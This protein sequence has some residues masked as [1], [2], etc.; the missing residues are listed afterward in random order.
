MG[1]GRC[2]KRLITPQTHTPALTH[3]KHSR[4]PRYPSTYPLRHPITPLPMSTLVYKFGGTSVG[5]AS[6][7]TDAATIVVRACE[8]HRVC[9]VSS[10]MSGV[11]NLLVELASD[12]CPADRRAELLDTLTERHSQAA[13]ALGLTDRTRLDALLDELRTL[14]AGMALTRIGSRRMRDR[15]IAGGERLAVELLAHAIQSQGVD[16]TPLHAD[17][18]LETQDGF[19][20]A[21]PR[22]YTQD[23]RTRAS[24]LREL[25][26]GITPVV[27]GFTGRG[28]DGDTR[29]LGRGGSDLTATLLASAIDADECVI[30]TDVPGV[31][32]CDPRLV[33]D[34]LPIEHLHYREAGEMAYFGSKVLHP[35]TMIPVASKGIPVTVRSTMDPDG[36]HTRIDGSFGMRDAAPATVSVLRDM[37]LVSIEGAGLAG[38]A[39]ISAR[40]FSALADAGVSVVMISQGSAE[41]T[42]CLGVREDD[43]EAAEAAI[44]SE[45]RLDLAR[46][47][48]E[49]VTTRRGVCMLTVV[50]SGMKHRTGAAGRMTT[51]LGRARVNILAIAQ[52]SSEL[53]V[54]FAIDAADLRAGARALHESMRFPAP[55][56]PS[57]SP[58]LS[59]ALAGVGLV[60]RAVADGLS[61]LGA[62]RLVGACD[63][64]AS[65]IDDR[66]FPVD[67]V[68]RLRAH[69]QGGA[70]LTDLDGAQS[71]DQPALK[72]LGHL[73]ESASPNPVLVDCTA[74]PGMV[75]VALQALEHGVDV[76]TANKEI[77]ACDPQRY[78]ALRD[79]ARASG[80][81]LMG[82]ATVG[83]GLPVARTLDTM[84]TA[85]DTIRAVSASLSGTI[86]FLLGGLAEGG[87][88]DELVA[89]AIELGYAE[90][91][92]SADVL[93]DDMRRKAIILAR[94]AG[95]DEQGPP[96][97]EPFADVAGL[98]AG[99]PA[100]NDA[101]RRSGHAIR[102]RMERARAEGRELR[103]LLHA[104]PGRRLT[105]GFVACDPDGPFGG[106]T[107]QQARVVIESAYNDTRPL[108]ITG[109]GAGDVTTA[110]GV[111]ADLALIAQR[112]RCGEDA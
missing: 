72:L 59:V 65:L 35:R 20:E 18:F 5:D 63:S 52:G 21:E 89:R 82:E 45:F 107:A 108:V 100:F 2:L 9:V 81:L 103:Y 42:I 111:L 44:Q 87:E 74:D 41:S 34:A 23:R 12:G 26:M 13:E 91:D 43:A 56:A 80:A 53:S 76:V 11:T 37:A 98:N 46:G 3:A 77:L 25:D 79:A 14:S 28:P 69:K 60:G 48:V 88:L 99:T 62:C 67:A 64:R 104:V 61:K 54:S 40:L 10:A 17:A 84:R 7:I 71:A 73:I 32:T 36:A 94:L 75:E 39:G 8:H 29:L 38:V 109:P 90:P 51:A 55:N 58:R 112:R 96:E 95:F 110:G 101:L 57:R 49:D 66:G 85:G 83:A 31:S 68:D 15:L 22:S 102:E 50:T 86:G 97:V 24:L 105:V 106:M 33:P 6:C 19:G 16:A 4:V 78:S 30:W 70:S 92:P 27:T 47:A 93:G 1:H